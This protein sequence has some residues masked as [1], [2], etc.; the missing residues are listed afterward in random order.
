[1]ATVHEPK[2]SRLSHAVHG[3]KQQVP[4]KGRGTFSPILLEPYVY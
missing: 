4:V 3:P 2:T 1:M